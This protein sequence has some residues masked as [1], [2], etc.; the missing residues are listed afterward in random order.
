M[1]FIVLQW[2]VK[3]PLLDWSLLLSSS[4]VWKSNSS[5]YT[6]RLEPFTDFKLQWRIFI[7]VLHN[8]LVIYYYYSVLCNVCS[9][10]WILLWHLTEMYSLLLETYIKD[11]REKHRLFNAIENIPCVADK[12][13]WSFNWIQR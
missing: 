8:R 3:H 4:N 10:L 5:Q 1:F 6:F 13:K 7:P 2:L 9:L 11:S 12:A